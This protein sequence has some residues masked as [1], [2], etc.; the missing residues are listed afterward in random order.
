M[1]YDHSFQVGMGNTMPK[2]VHSKRDRRD[3]SMEIKERWLT[4]SRTLLKV[5]RCFV[6]K[7]KK[8]EKK[9]LKDNHIVS[10]S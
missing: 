2:S 6:Q 5:R 8:L 9:N 3:I 10:V 7:D 1:I 4:Q